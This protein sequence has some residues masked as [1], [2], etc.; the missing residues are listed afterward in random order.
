MNLRFL[1]LPLPNEPGGEEIERRES[2]VNCLSCCS[3]TRARSAVG[4]AM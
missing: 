4:L 2:H 3:L 1:A